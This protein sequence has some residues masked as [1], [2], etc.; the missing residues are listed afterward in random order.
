MAKATASAFPND[1]D[2]FADQ[3]GSASGP[4]LQSD[5]DNVRGVIDDIVSDENI[6]DDNAASDIDLSSNIPFDSPSSGLASAD[7][8]SFDPSGCFSQIS[9]GKPRA[10][11]RSCVT[12]NEGPNSAMQDAKLGGGT[13]VDE[14]STGTE[15]TTGNDSATKDEAVTADEKISLIQ[16][17]PALTN[18]PASEDASVTQ[19]ARLA[20]DFPVTQDE[21]IDD[22]GFPLTQDEPVDEDTFGYFEELPVKDISPV[23]KIRAYWCSIPVLAVIQN[24]PVCNIESDSFNRECSESILRDCS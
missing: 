6:P 20:Q 15:D 13:A 19:D 11:V 24:I 4:L 12:V 16:N 5:S 21:P 8:L 14:T 9:R 17:L 2:P 7:I 1:V 3:V 22:Q 10:R 23:T 18:L